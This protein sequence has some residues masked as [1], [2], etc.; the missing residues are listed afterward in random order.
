[1][2]ATKAKP[3]DW[4]LDEDVELLR[5]FLGRVRSFFRALHDAGIHV[6]VGSPAYCVTCQVPWPCE[7]SAARD[8]RG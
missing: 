2:S 8:E 3:Y 6:G 7:C 5:R 4:Q 1:V